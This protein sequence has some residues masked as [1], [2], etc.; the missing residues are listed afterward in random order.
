LLPLFALVFRRGQGFSQQFNLLPQ[1]P[2]GLW[3]SG[4]GLEL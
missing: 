2:L 3:M 1:L 4:Y